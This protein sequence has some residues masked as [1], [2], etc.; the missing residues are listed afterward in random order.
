MDDVLAAGAYLD[1]YE[2]THD[3]GNT[4]AEV[5]PRIQLYAPANV[6]SP[7]SASS[8]LAFRTQLPV[9]SSA[10]DAS[11]ESLVARLNIPIH[12]RYRAAV[13]ASAGESQ[14][15]P[16][17]IFPPHRVK[18]LCQAGS[19]R[20]WIQLPVLSYT[21]AVEDCPEVPCKEGDCHFL[22]RS[23]M[24]LQQWQ[25]VG[26]LEHMESVW[27]TTQAISLI[28]MTVLIIEMLRK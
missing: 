26:N 27:W 8:Q 14:L 2:L 16:T 11:E 18:L 7:T 22:S 1:R 9:L 6:E 24:V 13:N 28:I 25:P 4:P 17:P 23:L 12:F 19:E 21:A 10:S 5:R 15:Q 20:T 3:V